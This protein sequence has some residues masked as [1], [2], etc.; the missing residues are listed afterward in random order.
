MNWMRYDDRHFGP[1]AVIGVGRFFYNSDSTPSQ[2]SLSTSLKSTYLLLAFDP[3]VNGMRGGPRTVLERKNR[4]LNQC[5]RRHGYSTVL[6]LQSEFLCSSRSIASRC[7]KHEV[8]HRE[9]QKEGDEPR[10]VDSYVARGD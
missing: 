6:F 5:Q 1:T 4:F 7:Q 9:E 3:L 8:D 10:Y 2:S